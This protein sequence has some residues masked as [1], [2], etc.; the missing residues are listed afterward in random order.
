[1]SEKALILS[2]NSNFDRKAVGG[3]SSS[4][5]VEYIN[6][7]SILNTTV[8]GHDFRTTAQNGLSSKRKG[9]EYNSIIRFFVKEISTPKMAAFKS[10]RKKF[11]HNFGV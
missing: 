8:A 9:F 2:H 3:G 1:M 5:Q 10:W 4:C 11:L 6:P 7:S